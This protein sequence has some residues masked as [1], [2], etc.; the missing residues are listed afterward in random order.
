MIELAEGTRLIANM[1]GAAPADVE[2][3]M[4]VVLDWIDPDPDLSLPAFRPAG[5]PRNPEER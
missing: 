5:P 4:P 2:V 1:T 3:G